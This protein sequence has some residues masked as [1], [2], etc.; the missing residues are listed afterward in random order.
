MSQFV[1]IL[2][3]DRVTV[4]PTAQC[5]YLS[6]SLSLTHSLISHFASIIVPPPPLTAFIWNWNQE[7][8]KDRANYIRLLIIFWT[9]FNLV[10]P[11]QSSVST[12]DQLWNS[13][14]A[15][16]LYLGVLGD[17]CEVWKEWCHFCCFQFDKFN[18]QFFVFW[19]MSWSDHRGEI[20][21]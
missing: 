17:V 6:L 16:S 20:T 8:G 19:G 11:V 10:K 7:T 4:T 12:V 13:G 1:I 9:D 14:T 5:G 15:A 2:I 18:H 21:V 3:S